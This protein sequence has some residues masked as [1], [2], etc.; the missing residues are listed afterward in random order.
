MGLRGVPVQSEVFGSKISFALWHLHLR[1]DRQCC[2]QPALDNCTDQL[3][4]SMMS[5]KKKYELSRK[6]VYTSML[7]LNTIRDAC[8]LL[9]LFTLVGN[10]K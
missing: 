8:F 2:K 10:E 1:Y 7:I 9:I 3:I 6:K 5:S 4:I